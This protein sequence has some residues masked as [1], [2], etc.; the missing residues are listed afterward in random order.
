MRFLQVL[1]LK[2]QH[3]LRPSNVFNTLFCLLLAILPFHVLLTVFFQSKLGVPFFASYKEILLGIMMFILGIQIIQKKIRL[4][5][6]RIDWLILGYIAWM[7][8][9]SL[10]Y[11][12]P[13]LH[14]AYG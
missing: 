6:E 1:F 13:L 9:V 14:I 7:T 11:P 5:F 12:E 8:G 3:S 4:H 2:F 10:F